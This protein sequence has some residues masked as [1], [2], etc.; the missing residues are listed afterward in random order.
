MHTAKGRREGGRERE[1]EKKKKKKREKREK[2]DTE[3]Q[4]HA[5]QTAAMLAADQS[6]QD[7]LEEA[8][9]SC[10]KQPTE[11]RVDICAVEMFHWGATPIICEID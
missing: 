5:T 7:H 3:K 2:T 6:A 10:K 9:R 1:R 8:Q 4:M 11:N